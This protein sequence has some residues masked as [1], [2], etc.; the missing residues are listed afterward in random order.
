M[1]DI[2]FSELLIVAL[3]ALLVIGPERLP[4]AARMAGFWIGKAKRGLAS[5]RAEMEQELGA[6]ELRRSLDLRN[7]DILAKERAAL[8]DAGQELKTLAEDTSQQLDAAT[9]DT[10]SD[11]ADTPAARPQDSA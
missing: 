11:T 2:G 10:S 9:R 5:I 7:Q 6:E 8:A 4:G 1:F 3:V